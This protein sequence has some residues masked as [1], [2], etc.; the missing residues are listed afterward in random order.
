MTGPDV[1]DLQRRVDRLEDLLAGIEV[2]A[3][4]RTSSAASSDAPAGF[5]AWADE[6][7]DAIC[8]VPRSA[9]DERYSALLDE[10][11]ATCPEIRAQLHELDAMVGERLCRHM[12]HAAEAAWSILRPGCPR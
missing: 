3:A 6:H 12:D 5:K 8:D 11:E 10:I 2:L 4:R 7:H 9:A 1:D